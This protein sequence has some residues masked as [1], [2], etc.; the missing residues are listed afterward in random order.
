MNVGEQVQLRIAHHIRAHYASLWA[1]TD[2]DSDRKE[3]GQPH[4]RRWAKI[5]SGRLR[6]VDTTAL[7][8]V[9]W[10]NE[11]VFTPDGQ[12]ASNDSMS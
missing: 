10:P 5:T 8:Q 2:D 1:T 12:P 7:K 3:E 6:T 9:L 11:L 4:P